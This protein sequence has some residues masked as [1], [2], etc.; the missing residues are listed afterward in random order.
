MLLHLLRKRVR[1]GNRS[2]T[3]CFRLRILRACNTFT[4]PL[5]LYSQQRLT[6]F[7]EVNEISTLKP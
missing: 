4:I 3:P 5:A 6:F 2:T 1:D 7:I